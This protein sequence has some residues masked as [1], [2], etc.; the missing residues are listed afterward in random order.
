MVGK[1]DGSSGVCSKNAIVDASAPVQKTVETG[2]FRAA[3]QSHEKFLSSHGA[4]L[5]IEKV[6][7]AKSEECKALRVGDYGIKFTL[8]ETYNNSFSSAG[9]AVIILSYGYDLFVEHAYLTMDF[10]EH[11]S[12]GHPVEQVSGRVGTLGRDELTKKEQKELLDAYN[13]IGNN[14]AD[15][16]ASFAKVQKIVM[17]HESQRVRHGFEGV[18]RTPLTDVERNM[19]TQMVLSLAGLGSQIV[20]NGCSDDFFKDE[21]R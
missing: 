10:V 6:S 16:M 3:F 9:S 1:G 18:L 19:K 12:H 20:A 5:T 4:R 7:G 21:L 14:P 13:K 2:V 15:T 17:M 11:D 8:S